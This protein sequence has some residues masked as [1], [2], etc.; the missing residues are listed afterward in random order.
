MPSMPVFLWGDVDHARY[1]TAYF[2]TYPGVWRHG[3]WIRFTER[4]SCVIYGRSDSTLNRG[5]V[6][7]GT[8]ELYRVVED[9]DQVVDSLVVDTGR[10]GHDGRCWLFVVL[11][12][13][14]VLDDDLRATI[15]RRLR[16][17]LSPRHVPDEILAIAEVPRTLNGKKLE[18]PVKRILLG[19]PWPSVVTPDGMANPAAL[20]FFVDL[21]DDRRTGNDAPDADRRVVAQWLRRPRRPGWRP[22][23]WWSAPGR[24]GRRARLAVRGRPPRHRLQLHAE[25]PHA[26]PAPRRV[27]RPAR[28]GAVPAAPVA[29]GAGGGAGRH[30]GRPGPGTVRAPGGPGRRGGPVRG[31][32]DRPSRR[33][34]E[35]L[36][37][38]LDVVRRLLAGETVTADR[39]VAIRDARIGPL[40]ATPVDVWIGAGAARGIDR[41]ARLGDGWIAGPWV[42]LDQAQEQAERYLERRAALGKSPGVVAIRRD[43]HVGADAADAHRVADP[44]LAAGYRGLPPDAPLV[45]GPEEVAEAILRLGELGYTDV[46]DPPPGRRPRRGARLLR[47]AGRGAPPGDER[48]MSPTSWRP[49]TT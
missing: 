12:D 2:D 45:G 38:G 16:A 35:D 34:A 25:R 3:D 18:V 8:S 27:G 6:R 23:G 19:E 4:G 47:A 46:L 41:A 26:R 29:P 21:A 42:P 30:P 32:G 17:E 33:R 39:P 13:G 37:A 10:L 9:L 11:A 49:S 36:E 14:A 20:E 44:V 22:G 40:P 31:D 24:P 1:R 43:V 48:L 7:I 5:G 28:R 15:A